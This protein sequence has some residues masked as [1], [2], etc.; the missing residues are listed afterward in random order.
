MAI[1]SRNRPK[2]HFKRQIQL[3]LVSFFPPDGKPETIKPLRM[4]RFCSQI[5]AL[6][7]IYWPGTY[8]LAQDIPTVAPN[9]CIS[10]GA[11]IHSNQ[12]PGNWTSLDALT[13]AS[14][15]T[16][17]E[18]YGPV[19]I[20]LRIDAQSTTAGQ[21][22]L[23]WRA[24]SWQN[25]H[26]ND[27]SFGHIQILASANSTDGTDGDW[28]L[29][30][31]FVNNDKDNYVFFPNTHPKWIQVRELQNKS[32]KLSR[33][34]V[35]TAAPAGQKNNIWL[36]FGDSETKSDMGVGTTH[37]GAPTYFSDAIYA[38]YPCYYPIVI[39][40]GKGGEKAT[41]AANMLGPILNSHPEIAFVG[42][43]YGLNDIMLSYPLLVPYDDPANDANT[44][45]LINA[46]VSLIDQCKARD[47]VPIPA[48]IPWVFFP[49]D[50]C[51]YEDTSA[52][53]NNGVHPINVNEL[54]PIISQHTSYAI[55]PETG[56]PYA[57][58]DTWYHDHRNDPEVFLADYVHHDK[59]GIDA[60]N[61][62]WVETA[63]EIIY[64]PQ[65]GGCNSQPGITLT[66]PSDITVSTN[67]GQAGITANWPAPTA[68]TDCSADS[69]Q[70]MQTEGPPAGSLFPIGS[71]TVSYEAM[72]SCGNTATCT[73]SVTV[74]PSSPCEEI[75]GFDKLGE[76]DNH[77]YYL[78]HFKRNWPEAKS[79]A[80]A[81]GGYPAVIT[82]QEENEFIRQRLQNNIAYIGLTDAPVEG[83][84]AWVNGEPVS[85]NLTDDN[86]SE[87]DYAAINFWNGH[88]Q[89]L[90]EV[91][92]KK[93]VL[94]KACAGSS[95]L[96]LECPQDTT[97]ILPPTQQTIEL[98]WQ[99]PAVFTAC[100][101]AAVALTL[102]ADVS[103]GSSQPP[104][105]YSI[106][107]TAT[108][109]CGN[110]TSCSFTVTI[111]ATPTTCPDKLDGFTKIGELNGHAYYLSNQKVNWQTA[112]DQ[113]LAQQGYLAT[114]SSQEENEFIRSAIYSDVFIGLHDAEQEGVLQWANGEPVTYAPL[115]TC[116]WCQNSPD[117]DYVS[118]LGWGPGEW[119][120]NDQWVARQYVLEKV[121]GSA[122]D[123][124]TLSLSCPND[125]TILL[126][127]GQSEVSLIWTLPV[128]TTTCPAGPEITLI[129]SGGPA[130][131][132]TVGAGS[133]SI[134]YTATDSCQNQ[135]TCTF[136]VQ[137]AAEGA[138]CPQGLDGFTLL[139]EWNDHTYF[140]TDE[141]M[142]WLQASSL[143]QANGGH[144]ASI[145]DATEN[146]FLRTAVSEQVHIGLND[147]DQEG[148]L[149]WSDQSPV[150][151][152]N[153]NT[154]CS[155]CGLNNA[156]NDFAVLMPWNGQWG[157]DDIWTARRAILEL[158]CT[159]ETHFRASGKTSHSKK[160]LFLYPNPTSGGLH[161]RYELDEGVAAVRLRI[162]D[163]YG[164]CLLRKFLDTRAGY[165]YDYLD[166][167]DR[168]PGWYLLQFIVGD[169]VHS[170]AVRKE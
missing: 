129:Q 140:I 110:T 88:W 108:D 127:Q 10:I 13:D 36:F 133:Y 99:E 168:A 48:R 105:T 145:Q 29:V 119:A 151:Y 124:G 138:P 153:L 132:S 77:A 33:L 122:V 102:S 25:R 59:N 83:Q 9:Q 113:S 62:I 14:D 54:D 15:K 142:T 123:N 144:L 66:C 56:I 95:D 11:E 159:A 116:S 152:T 78:S 139:G 170:V 157:F 28:Q 131:Y 106:N 19:T 167:S 71:T 61:A 41:E 73:F 147:L 58:F 53:Q 4:A 146:E 47:M 3:F 114:V 42:I 93:Y 30:K 86:N 154:T 91:I 156:S 1:L 81:H 107:Y 2:T 52:D 69:I 50:Y 38:A 84:P 169:E 111:Q 49:N 136:T 161:L 100:T 32:L 55:D 134:S 89:M 87:N 120:F 64:E 70:I 101:D 155:W 166:L 37:H 115:A 160:D 43:C 164:R 150:T 6:F 79:D 76:L 96:V 149:V 80:A 85:L 39:N 92:Q 34:D 68:F 16:I 31:D 27:N 57:D 94:E 22:I 104:G 20:S 141:K 65:T 60:F 24:N 45:S 82:S 162:L 158:P 128:A 44:Q 97:I 35:F 51:A 137:V 23:H 126:P 165:H 74:G 103:S 130:P 26:N 143:A 18:L 63:K 125:T 8:L 109:L 72:D 21:L 5:L 90:K 17:C 117:K 7:C 148:S 112:R 118:I 121:C 12:Q 75:E 163:T 40:G 135:T 67:P 98:Q 46:M